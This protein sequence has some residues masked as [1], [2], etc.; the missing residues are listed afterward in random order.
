MPFK[1]GWVTTSNAAL[2]LWKASQVLEFKVLR[3]ISPYQYSLENLFSTIIY[4]FVV[5]LSVNRLN[6]FLSYLSSI[7]CFK[8]FLLIY[9][10]VEI[11]GLFFLRL[12]L[13]IFERNWRISFFLS[14]CWIYFSNTNEKVC[15]CEKWRKQKNYAHQI[16]VFGRHFTMQSYVHNEGIKTQWIFPIQ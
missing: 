7:D 10:L 16:Y 15:I 13:T 11:L 1:S 9:C 3:T 2:E 6:L 4:H 5:L 8:Q 12:F 14:V